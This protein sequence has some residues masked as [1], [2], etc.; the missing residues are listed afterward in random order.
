MS[1]E[2]FGKSLS[3]SR[4]V[5]GVAPNRSYKNPNDSSIYM[6]PNE[7]KEN[8]FSLSSSN[9]EKTLRKPSPL[10]ETLTSKTNEL[11]GN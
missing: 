7:D 6:D 3:K 4:S 8:L 2:S 11:N 5:H 1:R 9:P 10:R